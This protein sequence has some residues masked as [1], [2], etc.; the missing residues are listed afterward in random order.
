VG[1]EVELGLASDNTI[2]SA[3]IWFDFS[4]FDATKPGFDTVFLKGTLQEVEQ[5]MDL[6]HAP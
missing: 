5:T 1:T 2:A 3:I 4:N 6:G